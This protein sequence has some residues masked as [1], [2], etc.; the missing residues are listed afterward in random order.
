MVTMSTKG[1]EQG[2]KIA[3]PLLLAQRAGDVK[4]KLDG[5]TEEAKAMNERAT[6][7]IF[8]YAR[9]DVIKYRDELEFGKWNFRALKR[10]Q[11]DD[12][13]QS[14][15]MW[16]LDRF[17]LGRAIPVVLRK[18][19]VMQGTYV[20][21]MEPVLEMPVFKLQ[22]TALGKKA[23][24]PTSGQHR[25]EAISVW[26]GL[27][28]KRLADLLRE[29]K[30]LEGQQLEQTDPTENEE[31]KLKEDDLEATLGFGGQWLAI[32]YDAGKCSL[33]V[34]LACHM[35]I[36]RTDLVDEPL[37]LHLSQNENHHV[38]KETPEEG[39][40]MAFR[41]HVATKGTYKT[42]ERN[43]PLV[44]GILVKWNELLSQDY[45]WDFMT[46]MD[47]I[48]LH[49]FDAKGD[50]KFSRFHAIMLS[51]S[52]GTIAH[53]S[54]SMERFL[55]TCFTTM[56]L[57]EEKIDQCIEVVNTTKDPSRKLKAQQA[58]VKAWNLILEQRMRAVPSAILHVIRGLMDNAFLR[59][60]GKGTHVE[61]LFC[62]KDSSRWTAALDDYMGVV[63]KEIPKVIQE[64]ETTGITVMERL[65]DDEREALKYCVAKMKVMRFMRKE[66]T[67]ELPQIPFMTRSVFTHMV[68]LLEP[69]NEA[70]LE[71][72]AWWEPLMYMADAHGKHWTPGSATATQTRAMLAHPD[73]C[74]EKRLLAVNNVMEVTWTRYASFLAL[75]TQ[76]KANGM[77]VRITIQKDLLSMFGV[78]VTGKMTRPTADA[79]AAVKK[80]TAAK[81][82]VRIPKKEVPSKAKARSKRKND[83]NEGI[84][85]ESH[86]VQEGEVHG[87]NDND[88]DDDD[89]EEDEC[90]GM[91]KLTPEERTKR[92]EERKEAQQRYL[93]E[94]HDEW[95]ETCS[96]LTTSR[97]S[98][99]PDE[100]EFDASPPSFN[101]TWKRV[102]R[103]TT[104]VPT[105]LMRGRGL[106]PLTTWEWTN[107]P[108]TWTFT[109][110]MRVYAAIIIYE[111]AAIAQY[112][113][114]L[115]L[116]DPSG[117][118]AALRQA[119]EDAVT[120]FLDTDAS[121]MTPLRQTTLQNLLC[122]GNKEERQ[123]SR[124]KSL[125]CEGE[126]PPPGCV[127][128][129]DGIYL[130]HTE[131]KSV[132][133]RP[134]DRVMEMN[135]ERHLGAQKHELQ[136]V[137]NCVQSARIAW[138][139]V[140]RVTKGRSAQPALDNEVLDALNKLIDVRSISVPFVIYGRLAFTSSPHTVQGLTQ[141]FQCLNTNAYRQRIGS[142]SS[143]VDLSLAEDPE[144]RLQV[145][146]GCGDIDEE[147]VQTPGQCTKV[148][149]VQI[150]TDMEKSLVAVVE[151]H[152]I[153]WA[154]EV[155]ALEEQRTAK[156]APKKEVIA[157]KVDKDSD[158]PEAHDDTD[159]HEALWEHN[160]KDEDEAPDAE[161][162]QQSKPKPITLPATESILYD[163]WLF[164]DLAT[165]AHGSFISQSENNNLYEPTE[166]AAHSSGYG[167]IE[168]N[169]ESPLAG[170]VFLD[171]QRIEPTLPQVPEE[172]EPEEDVADIADG[173]GLSTAACHQGDAVTLS[174]KDTKGAVSKGKR[175]RGLSVSS[176]SEHDEQLATAAKG[177]RRTSKPVPKRAKSTTLMQPDMAGTSSAPN[178]STRPTA[179]LKRARPASVSYQA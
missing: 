82:V 123:T 25:V 90:E 78:A 88:A 14:F 157:H 150:K 110:Q 176:A 148:F 27:Q 75:Q 105:A 120:L 11:T 165:T 31:N 91:K 155:P 97:P 163:T 115:I 23:M 22:E 152:A 144:E 142:R 135:R 141:I 94:I 67:S 47:P 168:R 38:Y 132:R 160:S 60:L 161:E 17:S 18:K 154:R 53:F 39:F 156:E 81:Q 134:E 5:R 51:A 57:N 70:L 84:D 137:I 145:H 86:D 89:E 16:G 119:M 92:C 71:V 35:H 153:K 87:D 65:T 131:G 126:L 128:W 112:R 37:G 111:S 173:A 43:L 3:D 113:Y 45:V 63:I 179:A 95:K 114:E 13:V 32:L 159:N 8:G 172:K 162:L 59:H 7:A 72:S 10:E 117:G 69:I 19:D 124:P 26:Y 178:V 108:T 109:R 15:L 42:V 24:R 151:R 127:R 49:I 28:E 122:A 2:T 143:N 46:T 106:V 177:P 12:L 74:P 80:S 149:R 41:K 167:R 83:D 104:S 101:E 116:G 118:A 34:S 76:L 79:F 68:Y 52:G 73:L 29:R 48:G 30:C 93:R 136:R 6:M 66:P 164:N 174:R 130:P 103:L 138:H 102:S 56:R 62:N 36:S 21:N 139:D 4:P 129:A 58:L 40:V 96:I 175:T 55:R 99:A 133:H 171:T 50:M 166:H 170:A 107:F 140:T 9:L 121:Q 61:Y 1:N 146:F 147:L 98:N 85:E 33:S 158:N 125:H 44:K 20:T 77:P 54:T 169:E 100:H 64:L